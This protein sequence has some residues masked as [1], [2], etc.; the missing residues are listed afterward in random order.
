TFRYPGS[1]RPVLD[2]FD[3]EIPAGRMVAVVGANGAGKSTLIKLLCR[4]YDPDDGRVTLDGIDLR[5]LSLEELRGDITVLFQQPVRYNDTVRQNIVYGEIDAALDAARLERAI[6][7]AGAGGIV[8]QLPQGVDSMLGRWFAEGTELSVGEWQRIA[9]ARAFLRR[10]PILVLDEP[11]SAMDP[12]AEA[13][14]LERFSRLAAG[15]TVLI[16]THR[17]S[18]AMFAD[19]IHVMDGGRVVESGTHDRLLAANGRY[20]EA[21]AAQLQRA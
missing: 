1:E 15:R 20:A 21:W 10:A 11:T 17:F 9:L 13:D 2:D 16:I 7:A 3:L 18:T 19:T 4:F 6:R 5:N 12:W 8:S 14:W